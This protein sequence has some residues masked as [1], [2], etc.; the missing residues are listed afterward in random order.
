MCAREANKVESHE[1]SH[2][3]SH[4]GSHGGCF[5]E[6]HEGSHE[7]SHRGVFDRKL[8]RKFDR[9]FGWSLVGSS[10]PSHEGCFLLS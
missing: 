6:S 8:G 10:I 7:E 9:E 2:E 4:E 1:R 5:V 3:R